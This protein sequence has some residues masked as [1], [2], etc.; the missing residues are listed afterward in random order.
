MSRKR[1]KG[2]MHNFCEADRGC[3]SRVDQGTRK[4]WLQDLVPQRAWRPAEFR[5][6]PVPRNQIRRHGTEELPLVVAK[7]CLTSCASTH[8]PHGT[9]PGGTG[10]YPHYALVRRRPTHDPPDLDARV[11]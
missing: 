7:A 1:T 4:G 6:R 2:A 8:R 9:A 3:A 10:S 5:L 11:S